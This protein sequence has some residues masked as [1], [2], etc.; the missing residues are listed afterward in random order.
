ME[1]IKKE[2]LEKWKDLIGACK[3]YYIDS[4]P[5]GIPDSVYDQWEKDAWEQDGF[6][7]R[8]Y[9]LET[10][11]PPGT[12][13]KNKNVDKI[14]K[15]KVDGKTMFQAL[16]EVSE[17][18]GEPCYMNLKYDGT[19]LAIYLDPTT[20]HPRR[21]VTVGNTKI[22]DLGVDQTSKLL[23]LIPKQFPKGITTIQAEALVDTDSLKDLTEDGKYRA[24][25]LANGLINSK[26]KAD[27]IDQLL[28]IRAYRWW[29]DNSPEGITISQMDYRDVLK[30]FPTNITTEGRVIF[31]P[32]DTWTIDEL[33]KIPGYTET[34]HTKTLSGSFLNDGWVVYLGN[35]SKCWGALKF[36][37]AGND[38]EIPTTTVKSIQW[39]DQA[40]KGKDS[41]SA[42]VIVEPITLRGCT[43]KKPS[44]G[45]VSKLLK[46][47]ITPGAEVKVILANSTIPMV[48]DVVK[49]GNGDFMFPV[50]E[51]G[52]QLGKKDIYG[53]NLKCGNPECSS[54]LTR[55]K[56]YLASL[57]SITALDLGKFLV[58]DRFKWEN[59][60]ISIDQLLQFVMDDKEDLARKYLRNEMTTD[61]QRKNFDLIWPAAWKTLRESF[62][63]SQNTII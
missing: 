19:S 27:E 26:Y 62:I 23:H 20:G 21:I 56:N 24:R 38:T 44:A 41:W 7:V 1:E 31:A 60:G 6:S 40:S 48:G 33:E 13:T 8:D 47:N 51:C 52:Y 58:I 25:Q 5:T 12:K 28:T 45:S 15:V 18:L 37:G 3:A 39:N 32:A 11:L 2:I 54:R 14:Q 30:S 9:I 29:V 36:S 43:V 22:G 16:K 46:N 4:V 59:T 42:N 61:L 63:N 53:S 35:T 17:G 34:D 55:M 10:F 50:C 57:K 49:G